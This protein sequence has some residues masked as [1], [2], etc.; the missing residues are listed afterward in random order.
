METG[1]NSAPDHTESFELWPDDARELWSAASLNTY[2]EDVVDIACAPRQWKD[3]SSEDKLIVL[4]KMSMPGIYYDP[5]LV[6]RTRKLPE[7]IADITFQATSRVIRK[8]R[9]IC[10]ATWT[11]TP[12]YSPSAVPMGFTQMGPGIRKL[13]FRISRDLANRFFYPRLWTLEWFGLGSIIGTQLI[14]W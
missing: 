11:E 13:G 2:L 4:V 6:Y 9:A 5:A 1:G 7:S 8:K 10:M 14:R 3:A 12:L